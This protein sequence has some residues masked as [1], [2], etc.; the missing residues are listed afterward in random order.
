MAQVDTVKA[1]VEQSEAA[2]RATADLFQ[3]KKPYEE[4][5]ILKIDGEE[6]TI[7]LRSIGRKKYDALLTECPPSTA[8]RAKGESY[9]QEKF[10]PKLMA[11]VVVDPEMSEVDWRNLWND[12]NWNRAELGDIFYACVGVC[13]VGVNVDPIESVSG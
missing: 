4:E 12:D 13:S 2:K 11:R 6:V 3:S 9:D 8:Q 10:A 5:K 1:K 7:L